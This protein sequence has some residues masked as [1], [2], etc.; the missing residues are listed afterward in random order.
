[1]DPQSSVQAWAKAYIESEDLAYKCDPPEAPPLFAGTETPM[2]APSRPGRPPELR[3]TFD[4]P[5]K[6]KLGGIARVEPRAALHH[7]SDDG[8]VAAPTRVATLSAA[9]FLSIT[10]S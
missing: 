8:T 10:S 4:K 9:V 6:F 3:V 5:R 1:M 7:K 2:Q